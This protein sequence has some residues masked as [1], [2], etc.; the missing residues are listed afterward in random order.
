MSCVAGSEPLGTPEQCTECPVGSYK[1]SVG[2]AACVACPGGQITDLTG[3]TA[4]SDCKGG[5][6]PLTHPKTLLS[7][8]TC[9][10]QPEK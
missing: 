10:G 1:D 9:A 2:T 8:Q 5:C 6:S 7:Y 4:L 3:S